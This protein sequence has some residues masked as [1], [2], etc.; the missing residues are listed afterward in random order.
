LSVFLFAAFPS[1]SYARMIFD[2]AK[3]C[4]TSRC[5]S[6]RDQ[7]TPAMHYWHVQWT[8][9]QPRL[10]GEYGLR[11]YMDGTFQPQPLGP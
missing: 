10:G 8:W 11:V 7:R 1:T 4:F 5:G 2:N 6:S 3:R 9:A